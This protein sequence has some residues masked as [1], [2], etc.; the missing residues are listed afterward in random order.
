MKMASPKFVQK[1]CKKCSSL[2]IFVGAK[3]AY[4]SV[5]LKTWKPKS[6]TC[7]FLEKSEVNLS[8]KLNQPEKD[9]NMF[10]IFA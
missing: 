5:Q 3:W 4:H 1:G 10:F 8:D 6:E 2:E 7:D 9:N